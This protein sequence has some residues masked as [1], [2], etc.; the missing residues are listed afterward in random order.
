MCEWHRGRTRVQIALIKRAVNPGG[1]TV[2]RDL[3]QRIGRPLNPMIRF[4]VGQ[5]YGTKPIGAGAVHA[6]IAQLRAKKPKVASVP[7]KAGE[8]E[9]IKF[10]VPEALPD[11]PIQHLTYNAQAGLEM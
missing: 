10:C 11:L 9:N 4:A 7:R 2:N 5:A 6:S 8:C 3:D 1:L